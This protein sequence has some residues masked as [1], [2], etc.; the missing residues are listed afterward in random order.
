MTNPDE[1]KDKLFDDL[2]FIISATPWT[3]KLIFLILC[4]DDTGFDSV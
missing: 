4:L 2:E 1:V 3:D